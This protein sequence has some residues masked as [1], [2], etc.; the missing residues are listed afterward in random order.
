MH[1][2]GPD[3]ELSENGEGSLSSQAGERL[4]VYGKNPVSLLHAT[5]LGRVVEGKGEGEMSVG[6]ANYIAVYVSKVDGG[7]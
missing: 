4:P 2:H 7:L 1:E 3:L 5:I 6:R